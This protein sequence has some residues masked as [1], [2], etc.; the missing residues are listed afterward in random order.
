MHS[1]SSASIKPG[2]K[3]SAARRGRCWAAAA[4]SVVCWIIAAVLVLS[5]V[6]A[7]PRAN[8]HNAWVTWVH[9]WAPTVNLG[10]DKLL[11]VAD[12]AT[13]MLA[14]H[15]VAALAWAA[16]GFLI[17]RIGSRIMPG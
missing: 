14:G 17:A 2:P 15:A 10:L 5:V 13:D 6:F 8:A 4:L 1:A 9:V 7:A 16:A 11:P 3:R 12:P